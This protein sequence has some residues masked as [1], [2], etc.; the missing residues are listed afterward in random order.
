M[1]MKEKGK[2]KIRFEHDLSNWGESWK[3]DIIF[4]GLTVDKAIIVLKKALDDL[5]SHK[6]GSRNDF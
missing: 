6:S 2:I 4:K 3:T 5:L 1:T